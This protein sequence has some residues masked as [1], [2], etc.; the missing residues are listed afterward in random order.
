MKKKNK[1]KTPLRVQTYSNKNGQV[2]M[3]FQYLPIPVYIH[4]MC[5]HIYGMDSKT[6]Y[7]VDDEGDS[8]CPRRYWSIWYD[9]WGW[10]CGSICPLSSISEYKSPLSI[11]YKI[12]QLTI[13]ST[14]SQSSKNWSTNQLFT[15]PTSYRPLSFNK[16]ILV[17]RISKTLFTVPGHISIHHISVS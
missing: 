15:H 2:L 16:E 13:N 11:F 9:A 3:Q 17:N 14:I 7:T 8:T 12:D 10:Y 1:K 5:V 6:D 4:C